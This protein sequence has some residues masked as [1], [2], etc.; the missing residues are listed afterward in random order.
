[1]VVGED[2]ERVVSNAFFFNRREDPADSRIQRLDYRDVILARAAMPLR[3]RNGA[4]A[5]RAHVI[6]AAGRLAR[7][8]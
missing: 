4:G 7:R 3:H 2:D 5:L 6:G 8:K 1:M